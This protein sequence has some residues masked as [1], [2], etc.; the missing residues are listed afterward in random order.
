RGMQFQADEAERLIRA[1]EIASPILSPEESV[2]IMET[3]DE[4]RRQIGLV[5][6]GE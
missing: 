3:M 5:Y 1:G 2:S 6:P 4:I